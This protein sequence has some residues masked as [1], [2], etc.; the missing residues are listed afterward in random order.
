MGDTEAVVP[1]RD[2][3][4]SPAGLIF[5]S[6]SKRSQTVPLVTLVTWWSP[7]FQ[8]TDEGLIDNYCQ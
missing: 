8:Q 6:S 4:E 5:Q 7:L 1:C 2:S 3:G